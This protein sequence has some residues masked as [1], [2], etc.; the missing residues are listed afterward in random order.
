MLFDKNNSWIWIAAVVF[1]IVFWGR[2]D[3][4]LPGC[5]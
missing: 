4:A 3:K 1:F 5:D 2:N